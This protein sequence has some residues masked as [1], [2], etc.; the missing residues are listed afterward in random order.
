MLTVRRVAVALGG[1][2]LMVLAGCGSLSLPAPPAPAAGPPPVSTAAGTARPCTDADLAV[3]L[4]DVADVVDDP[5][6]QRQ[7]ALLWTNT[8]DTPCAMSGFGIVD[9]VG[10]RAPGRSPIQHIPRSAEKPRPVRLAPGESTR[11]ILRFV[12][13]AP[14]AP[15]AQVWTPDR[16]VFAPP[17][18][19]RNQSL[20]WRYGPVLRQDRQ[21]RPGTVFGPVTAG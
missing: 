4:V 20:A 15:A 3:A 10:P 12:P 8:A 14:D 13:P 1:A 18:E 9:L 17:G 11:C 6:G 21:E 5:R 19:R 16:V 2:A 7:V